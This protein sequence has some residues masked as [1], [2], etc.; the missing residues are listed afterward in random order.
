MEFD[1]VIKKRRSIRSYKDQEVSSELIEKLVDAA[2]LAPTG[3]N[4]QPWKF[5]VI[6]DKEKLKEIKKLYEDARIELKIYPQDVSFIEK[7]CIILVCS[8]KE[9]PWAKNDCFLAI[10]NLILAA[11]NLKLGS[12]CLGAL[13]IKAK[14]LA[15]MIN[16]PESHELVLP[17]AIGYPGK[18]EK[19]P[20]KKEIKDL[21]SYEE[22]K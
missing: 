20:D 11:T 3:M 6:K 7:T 15:E 13:M 19:M 5:I 2:R 14:E 21:L 18:E 8:S 1:D 16:M 12:L 17:I 4:C 10:E 9:F 22:F